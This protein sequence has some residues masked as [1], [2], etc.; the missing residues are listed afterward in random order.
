MTSKI[1]N[2]SR[3]SVQPDSAPSE[4]NTNKFKGNPYISPQLNTPKFTSML[5][6]I[7]FRKNFQRLLIPNIKP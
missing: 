5:S 4:I 3:A 7:K 2:T 6:N 1:L